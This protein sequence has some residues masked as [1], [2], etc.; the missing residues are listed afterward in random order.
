MHVG[1]MFVNADTGQGGSLQFS[2]D[3]A[4]NSSDVTGIRNEQIEANYDPGR[5]E[6]RQV[7]RHGQQGAARRGRRDHPRRGQGRR[8]PLLR[9]RRRGRDPAGP[10]AARVA[11]RRPRP[12]RARHRQRHHQLHPRPDGLQR[13]LVLRRAGGGPGAGLRRGGPHR[14]RGGLRRRGQGRDPRRHGLPQPGDGRRRAPR[15][16][17]RDHRGGRGQRQGM[18]YVIKLLAICGPLRRRQVVSVYGCTRR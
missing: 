7:G 2:Y 9:G 18:G 17:H 5:A 6:Q 13:G 3:E 16:H 4:F 15:G 10:P 1:V 12:S 11:R 8:R 14:R